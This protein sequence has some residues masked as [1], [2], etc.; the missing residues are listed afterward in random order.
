MV[1]PDMAMAA[2]VTVMAVPVMVMAALDTA[3]LA[4]V[5]LLHHQLH[6]QHLRL[7]S[8]RQHQEMDNNRHP[9]PGSAVFFACSARISAQNE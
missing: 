6:Q 3:T 2:Q 8:K 5:H 9:S 1:A 4:T 7:A